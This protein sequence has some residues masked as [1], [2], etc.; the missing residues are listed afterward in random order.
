MRP[1]AVNRP[2]GY[3]L[4]ELLVVL[5]ILGL[6]AGM[7]MPAAELAA[8]RQ[9]ERELKRSLWSIR[10]A[11]DRYKAASDSGAFGPTD[12]TSG[13]PAT[14][15]LLV[16]PHEDRRPGQ[17]GRVLRFMRALPRDP[18]ASSDVPAER[19][20]GLRGYLS[21]TDKPAPGKDVY[22][23][24]SLSEHKALDGTRLRDW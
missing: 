5:A 12:A 20:W 14:L 4:I 21:E 13:Y 19:S 22:D 18:F 8:Q 6:L 15:Q 3:T 24:Y 9:K 16:Q 23:V 17:E 11:L 1:A 7:A 2:R 10:D